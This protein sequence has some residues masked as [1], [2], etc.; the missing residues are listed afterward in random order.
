MHTDDLIVL[1]S[2]YAEQVG[3]SEATVSNWIV[4]H[5]RLFERLRGGKGTTIRTYHRVL[6]WFS[7]HWPADLPW[8][9]GIPRPHKSQE[10]A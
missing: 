10:V 8:P 7:D 5:A 2:R 1:A 9:S 4:G 3:R 6:Q